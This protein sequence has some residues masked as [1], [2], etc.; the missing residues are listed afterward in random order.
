MGFLPGITNSGTRNL[1]EE[2]DSDG[3]NQLMEADSDQ[4]YQNVQKI[5]KA[6][7]ISGSASTNPI[8]WEGQLFYKFKYKNIIKIK[9]KPDPDLSG[10]SYLFSEIKK[11]TQ[12]SRETIPLNVK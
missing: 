9:N 12:K 5:L 2:W 7:T 11:R 6:V 3:N 1:P 4:Q 10:G 8:Y